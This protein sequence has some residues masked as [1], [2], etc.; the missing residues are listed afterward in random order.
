MLSSNCHKLR[1]LAL[2]VILFA[3]GMLSVIPGS[4]AQSSLESI[5]EQVGSTRELINELEKA[6]QRVE[7]DNAQLQS[8]LDKEDEELTSATV[9]PEMLQTAR[10]DMDTSRSRLETVDNRLA[11]RVGALNELDSELSTMEGKLAA[12]STEDLA[13]FVGEVELDLKRDLRGESA[14]FLQTLRDYRDAVQQNLSLTRERL[15]LLRSRISLA[16]IENTQDLE[17]DPRVAGLRTIV[18]RLVRDSIRLGNEAAAIE[19]TGQADL[20][21]KRILE[22]ESD[23]ALMRSTA[24][25][26]DLDVLRA[27]HRMTGFREVLDD[28]S[29]PLRLLQEIREDIGRIESLLATRLASAE[30]EKSA[31]SERRRVIRQQDIGGSAALTGL[32]DKLDG[33]AQLLNFQSTDIERTQQEL[34]TLKERYDTIIG[35]KEGE[36][37]NVRHTLPTDSASLSRVQASLVLLPEQFLQTVT[38]FGREFWGRIRALP[39]ERRYILGGIVFGVIVFALLCRQVA[40]KRYVQAGPERLTAIPVDALRRN[41]FAL[42]PAL[43]WFAVSIYAGFDRGTT[44]LV[45]AVLGVFPIL[46]LILDLC[47]GLVVERASGRRRE[48]GRRFMKLMRISMFLVAL[49]MVI[50]I[51]TRAVPM[52]PSTAALLDRAVF[53]CLI[54]IAVPALWLRSLIMASDSGQRSGVGTVLIGISSLILPLGF[55][56]AGAIGVAGWINLGWQIASYFGW[57][58]AIGGILA[59]VVAV[60]RD[61]LT[62]YEHRLDARHPEWATF[63]AE[64]FI[65]PA[66]RL[67]TLALVVGA[68][69]LLFNIYGWS[70]ETPIVRDLI[71]LAYLP[72]ITLGE[73]TL[74]LG[75]I[76][77]ALVL[78]AVV[79]W[80]G[81]WSRNVTYNLAYTGVADTGVRQSLSTFTQY[82]VI[83]GGV[84]LTLLLIGFDLTTLTVFAA[85]LG[86][87]IGFGLQN[88]VNNFVSGVLVLAERPLR[89]DDRVTV[90]DRTGW[91]TRIGIR[92]LTIRTDDSAEVIIPNASVISEVFMNMTKTDDFFRDIIHIGISYDDDPRKAAEVIRTALANYADVALD[93]APIIGIW[94][95]GDSSIIIRVEYYFNLR[96]PVGDTQIRF[97]TMNVI[98]EAVEKAGITMPN[99]T[100]DLNVVAKDT[101]NRPLIESVAGDS[102]RIAP[103]ASAV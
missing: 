67:I 32:F 7:T 4:Q 9:R 73:S 50:F 25:L 75:G 100:Y 84:L 42:L 40:F 48:V 87:G 17:S 12:L 96:N 89:I 85:S 63:W 18:D 78:V 44:L 102:A 58:L 39:M 61:L 82:L 26:A 29:M 34:Q 68:G 98:L 62:A 97:N 55:L 20:E 2:V 33:L 57:L 51:L 79:F 76:I 74:T 22:L 38:S 101:G 77:L 66:F 15:D 64:N 103:R 28:P 81:G 5:Q 23:E 30:Q 93:P 83:V 1:R 14:T 88:I 99:P 47:R 43:I 53:L 11:Q 46:K 35:R 69:Y 45:L 70:A 80:I 16:A 54:F 24:R 3:V 95:F 59:L 37:L 13:T 10:F 41:M 90:G 8:R 86:V 72:M 52:L 65:E 27:S 56:A 31:L 60:I 71:A 94:E 6:V 36:A 19:P 92:S 49:V 91:V 21:R